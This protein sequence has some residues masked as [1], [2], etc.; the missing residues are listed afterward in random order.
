[1]VKPHEISLQSADDMRQFFATALKPDDPP[2]R[3]VV[4]LWGINNGDTSLQNALY[5]I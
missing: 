3:G 5:L 2:C 1:M 4:Y